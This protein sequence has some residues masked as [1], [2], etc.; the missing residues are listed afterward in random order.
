MGQEGLCRDL[1]AA[2][3]ERDEWKTSALRSQLNR[4]FKATI[5]NLDANRQSFLPQT[6]G[7]SMPDFGDSLKQ[8]LRILEGAPH[9]MSAGRVAGNNTESSDNWPPLALRTYPRGP[10]TG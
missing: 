7:T 8:Q 2:L 5:E 10:G 4:E 6:C 9:Q 3:Q 1:A